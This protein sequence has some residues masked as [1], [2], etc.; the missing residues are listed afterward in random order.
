MRRSL[1]L[2][3]SVAATLVPRF[4]LAFAATAPLANLI[5]AV[6]RLDAF[7]L[8]R[9]VWEVIASVSGLSLLAVAY[10]VVAG[11]VLGLVSAAFIAIRGPR[12]LKVSIG[13]VTSS[14]TALLAVLLGIVFLHS[15]EKWLETVLGW[16]PHRLGKVL[17]LVASLSVAALAL[18]WAHVKTKMRVDVGLNNV[19]CSKATRRNVLTAGGAAVAASALDLV[20][21]AEPRQPRTRP[22][23]PR[24]NILL[25]TFDA[26][27]AADMSVYGYHLPTT[28]NL[29]RYAANAAVFENFYSCSTFTT[30]SVVAFSCGRYPSSTGVYHYGGRLRGDNAFRT[31]PH[32]LREAGYGTAASVGNPAAHPGACHIEG[33]D[34]APP[35][36]D[37]DRV[38]RFLQTGVVDQFA[39]MDYLHAFDQTETR[40]QIITAKIVS[41]LFGGPIPIGDSRSPPEA[42]F[43]EAAAMWKRMSG[44]KFLHVHL[45]APHL[46]YQPSTPFYGRFLRAGD[47]VPPSWSQM[48]IGFLNNDYT[49]SP[50]HQPFFDAL[51]RRY[52]EWIAN[53]D[54][55]FGDFIG[56]ME[57]RGELRDTV[58]AISADHG[59]SFQGG[60]YSHGSGYQH[61]TVVHIPL[62]IRE[63]GRCRATRIS[64]PCDASR[65]APTL[66]DLAGLEVPDWME[67]PSLN[68][69]L[70]NPEAESG[71]YAFTQYFELDSVFRPIANGT[72]GVVDGKHQYIVDLETGKGQLY[73]LADA[74]LHSREI[75]ARLPGVARTLHDRIRARFPAISIS[76]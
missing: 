53:A 13:R 21:R 52:D 19:F 57:A 33:Y 23:G 15:F 29:A 47:L 26:L 17:F 69:V 59:E 7:L 32:V 45:L 20:A 49:Y 64:T 22:T 44:P 74:H 61:G 8:Y 50:Q 71:G 31:L 11:S 18:V 1:K 40:I 70:A 24:P 56:Q 41:S 72:I 25:I 39:V 28:P 42:S 2:F 65:L 34:L 9:T 3:G 6:S 75:S 16:H 51:R 60:F 10:G 66:L 73:E 43:H 76:A 37:H 12:R 35:S 68:P 30:A 14:L 48:A 36:P 54:A 38:L 46:P 55:A 4:C 58:V 63:P 67:G 27:A 62:I 5:A